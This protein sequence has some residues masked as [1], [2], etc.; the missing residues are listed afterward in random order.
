MDNHGHV[1]HQPLVIQAED[2]VDAIRKARQ[3]VDGVDVEVWKDDRLVK[4]IRGSNPS[5][6][7]DPPR[8]DR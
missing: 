2:D 3:L 1:L 7:T 6:P 8:S 4:K 5:H